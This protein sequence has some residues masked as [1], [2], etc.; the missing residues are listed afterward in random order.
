MKSVFFLK[1]LKELSAAYGPCI[2]GYFLRIFSI[3]LSS[4]PIVPFS[5]Q[6]GL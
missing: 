1:L 5:P 2:F 6:C 3:K 4:L